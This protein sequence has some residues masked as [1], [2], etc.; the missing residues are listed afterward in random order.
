[1]LICLNGVFQCYEKISI[2]NNTQRL[3]QIKG[4]RGGKKPLH[5]RYIPVHKAFHKELHQ[6]T[7]S[8]LCCHRAAF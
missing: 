4:E 6:G 8:L 2:F 3:L 5:I 7:T 1:M